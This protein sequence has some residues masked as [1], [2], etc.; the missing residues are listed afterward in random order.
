MGGEH[1]LG[2]A[3]LNN[4][5]PHGFSEIHYAFTS[6]AANNGSAFAG[7]TAA[8]APTN[9]ATIGDRHYDILLAIDMLVGRFFIIIPVLALAGHL[10][11]K[12]LIAQSAGSFPVNGVTFTVLLIGVVVIVGALTFLPALALGRWWNT[13]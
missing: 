10:A 2:L 7:L 4:A 13:S 11:K 6:G 12:K 9:G 3:G 8:P 5:G 1:R